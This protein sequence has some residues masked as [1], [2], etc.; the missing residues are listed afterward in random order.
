MTNTTVPAGSAFRHLFEPLRIG[1]FEVRNRIL[2]ATHGTGLPEARDLRYLQ[3]RARGG[4]ALLGVHASHGVY[5]YSIGAGPRGTAP[6]WDG[7]WISPVS[8]EGVAYF[9]DTL[10]PGLRQRASVIHA[11][12]ARCFGQ[13]YHSGAAMHAAG[14]TPVVAPSAVPDPYEAAVPHPLSD[15]EIEELILAFAHGIRRAE[16]SGQDAAE[17]HAPSQS[18]AMPRGPGPIE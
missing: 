5:S 4:A 14:V 11:E 15:A 10:I 16:E 1:R 3:E 2:N 7:R 6:D 13:V 8:P 18:G 9:D 17:I 12:G